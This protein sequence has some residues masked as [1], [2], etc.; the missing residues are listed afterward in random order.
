MRCGHMVGDT[1]DPCPQRTARIVLLETA[2]QLKMDVLAQVAAL[3]WVSLVGARKPFERGTVFIRRDPVQVILARCPGRDGLSY[4][5]TQGSRSEQ[6]FLTHLDR[7]TE[8]TL[9]LLILELLRCC[10]FAG[11][12]IHPGWS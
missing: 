10:G 9:T 1:I 12:R 8:V 11:G 7:K 5:H 2:P 4:S 6:M 3:L